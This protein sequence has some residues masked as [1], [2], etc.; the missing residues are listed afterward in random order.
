MQKLTEKRMKFEIGFLLVSV[1]LIA[2]CGIVY[3]LSIGN[4]SSYL[5]GN[6]VVQYS[7]TIGSFMFAMGIGSFLSRFI[8][9]DLIDKFILI[10]LAVGIFGGFSAV[11]LLYAYSSFPYYTVAMFTVIFIIGALIG[12]EI[13][14][15]TRLIDQRYKDIKISISNALGFDYIGALIGSIGFSVFLLPKFGVITSSYILGMLNIIVVFLNIAVYYHDIRF[16]KTITILTLVTFVGLIYGLVTAG[17]VSL[18]LEQKL[19][20][21]RIIYLEQTPYQKIVMTR[22]KE[23]F[24]LFLDGN[25]Q[26]SATDEYRYHEALVHPAMV[27]A[28]E[29][30]RILVLGGGDGLAVREILKYPSVEH[31]TL[32]D[33]D[34]EMTKLARTHKRLKALN[35]DSLENSKV[36]VINEDAYQYVEK[37]AEKYDVVLIDLPDPNVDALS[38]LYSKTFYQLVGNRLSPGGVVNVQSTS[39]YFAPKVYWCVRE[40]MAA[41][42]LNTTGYHLEVPSFGDWGFTLASNAPLEPER[43]KVK[44]ETRFLNDDQ[45]RAMFVFSKDLEAPDVEV[46]RIVSPV[47]L[48]YYQQSWKYWN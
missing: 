19:Y 10:E 25:I 7:L 30:K 31:I 35:G 13:P 20:R 39:P 14:I 40:T 15:L 26:F 17:P 28:K 47:I 48:E 27:M 8:Q 16:K 3:E 45:L 42:G 44:V 41:S 33:L 36:E 34:P 21:D 9:K 38:K 24:R 43:L 5:M 46:N 1:F 11:A 4:L 37:T 32:V 29:A 18:I 23:D 6:T 2:I 22:D 12:V